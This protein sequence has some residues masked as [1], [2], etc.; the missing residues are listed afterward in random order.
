MDELLR[1]NR[2]TIRFTLLK[3]HQTPAKQAARNLGYGRY[4]PQGEEN[5]WSYEKTH[6]YKQH[7][8]VSYGPIGVLNY[9]YALT[10]QTI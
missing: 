1:S 3:W 2:F 5:E 9:F 8:G 10:G 7:D 6:C 4:I